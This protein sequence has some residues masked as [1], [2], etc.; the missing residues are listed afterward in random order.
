MIDKLPRPSPQQ[1]NVLRWLV[2][3]ALAVTYMFTGWEPAFYAGI[4]VLFLPLLLRRK[5]YPQ[6]EP[7]D[8]EGP[9]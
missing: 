1:L 3:A 7:K 6:D 8:P 4:A 2:A 9:R 5:S